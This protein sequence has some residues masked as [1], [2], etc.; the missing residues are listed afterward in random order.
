MHEIGLQNLEDHTE[1]AGAEGENFL[2]FKLTQV[3][4]GF[5]KNSMV[6][7]F[8]YTPILKNGIKNL[9][10]KDHIVQFYCTM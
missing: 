6:L 8:F 10:N 9:L 7:V 5:F 3:W 4:Q 2:E 1:K